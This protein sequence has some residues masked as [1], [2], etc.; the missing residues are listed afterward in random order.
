MSHF[1]AYV[2][3]RLGFLNEADI[4]LYRG[5]EADSLDE[6]AAALKLGADVNGAADFGHTPLMVAAR[7]SSGMMASLLLEHGARVNTRTGGG[8]TSMLFAAQAS[9]LDVGRRLAAYGGN[10]NY[11]DAERNNVLSVCIDR[12]M[13]GYA[14]I[15]ASC[16]VALDVNCVYDG[17][18][19]PLLRAYS[20]KQFD[21]CR[22]LIAMGSDPAMEDLEGRSFLSETQHNTDPL[23]QAL[24]AQARSSLERGVV[25]HVKGRRLVDAGVHILRPSDTDRGHMA[26]SLNESLLELEGPRPAL[27][28]EAG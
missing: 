5:I 6:A 13:I 15:A 3:D 11:L 23:V 27:L 20:C 12:G 22:W 16:N 28:G 18:V 8:H 1:P 21:F 19:S 2:F 9:N 17:E 14:E 24:V 25:S 26:G 10:P 4:R 7:G